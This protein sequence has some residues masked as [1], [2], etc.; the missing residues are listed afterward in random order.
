MKSEFKEIEKRIYALEVRLGIVNF[1]IY[2]RW[3]SLKLYAQNRALYEMQKE[4]YKLLE[5]PE[6]LKFAE[7][8]YEG[9]VKYYIEDY[10]KREL[11]RKEDEEY[12]EKERQRRERAKQRRLEKLKK[13]EELKLKKEQEELNHNLEAQCRPVLDTGSGQETIVRVILSEPE[14]RVE[15]S[16]D[17]ATQYNKTTNQPRKSTLFPYRINW[18]VYG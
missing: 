15:R 1:Y 7:E 2:D 11:R 14:G 12:Q 3:E 8:I 17:V 16:Q 4:V 6:Y 13:Q 5:L 18:D 9:L 10:K